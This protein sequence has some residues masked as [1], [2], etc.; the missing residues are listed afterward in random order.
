MSKFAGQGQS[1]LYNSDGSA[2]A[3]SILDGYAASD[4][5]ESDGTYNYYGFLKADGS[6]YIMRTTKTNT[7]IRY[8]AG[9]S[10][11]TTSW[12]GKAGLSYNY[13]NVIF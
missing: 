8:F 4:T 6:W 1:V 3:F 5:D 11:Y 12:T 7:E 2:V 13:F 9:T 10:D